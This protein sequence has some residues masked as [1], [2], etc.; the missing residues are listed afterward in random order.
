MCELSCP[1]SR[2]EIMRTREQR[3]L[4]LLPLLPLLLLVSLVV[5]VLGASPPARAASPTLS[6]GCAVRARGIPSCGAYVGAAYGG[7]ADVEAVGDAMG[8][9]LGVHRTYWGAGS[10]ALRGEDR[11]GRRRQQARALDELQRRRTRGPTMAAGKGDAWAR[12]LATRMKSVRGPVWVAVA[13]RARGR[14]RH[15]D[16]GSGCRHASRRSCARPPPTSATRSS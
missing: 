1:R 7:N 9:K 11:H 5:A 15:A 4:S 6:N 10:V 8:K 16:R 13:P 2:I 14:R 3:P 12:N